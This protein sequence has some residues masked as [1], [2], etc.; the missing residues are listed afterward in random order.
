MTIFNCT[1]FARLPREALNSTEGDCLR[2]INLLF[3]NISAKLWK[4][5]RKLINPTF[6]QKIVDSFVHIFVKHGELIVEQM[7]KKISENTL[8]D[9]DQFL[10][11]YT[12]NILTG[13]LNNPLL[14]T[15]ET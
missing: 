13:K 12:M 10:L 7:E 3:V 6:N 9:V 1:D 2:S 5:N 15:G 4:K 11:T 14:G 8:F